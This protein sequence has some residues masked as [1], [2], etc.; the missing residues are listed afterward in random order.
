MTMA[1]WPSCLK[2][3]RSV[4]QGAMRLEIRSY[5]MK[6]SFKKQI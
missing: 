6:Y 1:E 3:K 2:I 5:R 4:S